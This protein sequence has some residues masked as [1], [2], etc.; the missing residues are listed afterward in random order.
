[1]AGVPEVYVIADAKMTLG[2]SPIWSV[3]EERIY[4]VGVLEGLIFSSTADG[5]ELRVW[6]FSGPINSFVLRERGGAVLTSHTG[7]YLFD[8]ESGEEQKVFDADVGPS[9]NA[10]D[11]KVDRQGR[12][13]FGL[14]DRNLA[15]YDAS[16]KS[17]GTMEPAGGY[18]QMGV[19]CTI[20]R[21]ISGVGITN[22]PCFSP[23]GS[24]FFYGDSWT[25]EL[26]ACD[27]DTGTGDAS[28]SRLLTTFE[29]RHDNRG[30]LPRPDGATVDEEGFIWAAAVY[31]G[32]IRRYSPDGALDR[33]I[34]VPLEKPT[35]VAF[36]GADLDTLFVTS[37]SNRGPELDPGA[38]AD[39]LAGSLF[40]IRG[41]GVRGVPERGFCG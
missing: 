8:L 33:R 21:L 7:V 16:S 5:R 18:Y 12:F 15:R 24:T 38:Q 26:Y 4:W 22:G 30:E 14:S 11:G 31:G 29:P 20:R 17:L 23:N 41:L 1:M 25:R 3:E 34:Q 19:D 32:E 27:Y 6:R 39:P 9:M 28:N 10:N 13:V 37:M 35:S 36:G 2:E 40:A